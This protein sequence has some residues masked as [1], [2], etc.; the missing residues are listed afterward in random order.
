MRPHLTVEQRQLALRLKARGLSLREIGFQVGCSHQAVALIVS[1]ASMRPDGWAP[2]P[3]PDVEQDQG[4]Y[5]ACC[6]QAGASPIRGQH[7]AP[8]PCPTPA[9]AGH[10]PKIAPT[11]SWERRAKRKAL[12]R[13][14]AAT[15]TGTDETERESV[16]AKV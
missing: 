2:G 6:G 14:G 16:L 5:R 3:G 7:M 15:G 9:R 12:K 10:R 13:P 8:W 11:P 4:A 1:H